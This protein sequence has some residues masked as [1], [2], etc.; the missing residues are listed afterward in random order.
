[1]FA[2]IPK[3][4][5]VDWFPLAMSL[6]FDSDD[7]FINATCYVSTILIWLLPTPHANI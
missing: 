1:M 7:M 6:R 4:A 5:T 3:I 2:R